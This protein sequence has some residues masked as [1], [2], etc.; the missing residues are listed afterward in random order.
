MEINTQKIDDALRSGERRP[1]GGGNLPSQAKLTF[2]SPDLLYLFLSLLL[3][4]PL[5]GFALLLGF[6]T[7]L[8]K[9]AFDDLEDH[10][11]ADQVMALYL[12]LG[13]GV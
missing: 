6:L 5:A 3:L 7:V 10:Q 4:E 12:G 11:V 2:A 1:L 8:M 13:S 9:L